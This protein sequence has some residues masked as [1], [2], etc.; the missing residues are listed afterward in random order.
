MSSIKSKIIPA[1]RQLL[2]RAAGIGA[3]TVLGGYATL[4]RSQQSV[5][6]G[7]VGVK[8]DPLFVFIEVGDTVNWQ[9]MVGHNVETI[10]EMVPA[11]Q[12]KFNTALGDDVSLTFNTPGIVMYKCTPHWGARMGGGIVVG[13][14]DDPMAIVDGYTAVIESNRAM[15]LPAKGLLKKLAKE[16]ET[17]GW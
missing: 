2:T 7:A 5:T 16:I 12:E 14:P 3:L 17:K 10:D 4:A 8:F 11:G 1:R 9:G 15:L 6:I 13:K